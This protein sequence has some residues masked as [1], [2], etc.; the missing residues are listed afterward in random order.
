MPNCPIPNLWGSASL[1]SRV[2]YYLD[3]FL[4]TCKIFKS[5]LLCAN[6]IHPLMSLPVV[7]GLVLL[8]EADVTILIK[9]VYPVTRATA[10]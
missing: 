10:L 1:N 5:K 4:I 2:G 6:I 7:E 8:V 3:G 9:D